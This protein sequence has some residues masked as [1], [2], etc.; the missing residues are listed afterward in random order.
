[1]KFSYSLLKKLAPKISSKEALIEKLNFHAFEAVDVPG[2]TIEIAI[3]PNRF[4]D[5]SSHWG[6][7]QIAVALFGGTL[8]KL[9]GRE[10]KVE[11]KGTAP[12][13][14]VTSR[15]SCIRYAGRYFEIPSQGQSPDWLKE[16]LTACGMRSINAVVD[17]MNYVMLE[18]GQPLHAFDAELVEGGIEVRNAKAGEEMRTIDNQDIK[19]GESDLVI[20]DQKGPL[21]I[22]GIKGGKRAEIT[23]R[24]RKIIVEAAN[25][26]PVGIYKTTRQINLLTDASSRFAHGLSPISVEWGMKRATELLKEVAKAKVGE[27][28][29]VN[30]WKP[31]KRLLKF[32]IKRFNQLTGLELEEKEALGYLKKLG[33][34]ITGRFVEIP[35]TRADISIFEDL[36]EEVVNLYGYQKLPAKAPHVP[37]LPARKEDDVL[38]KDKARAVLKGFGLSEV[39]NYTF[40][41]RQDL[42][43]YAEPKWWNAPSLLNPVSAE[44]QYLRPAL[45]IG[46]MKNIES[47]LRFF[48]DVRVFEV[49]KTFVEKDKLIV[50]ETKLG[51]A[52][53]ARSGNPILELKGMADELLKQLGLTDI[54]FRDLEW[55]L[56]HLEQSK[57]LRIESDHQV[58]G[59]LGVPKGEQGMAI[60]EIDLE[61]SL[62]LVQGE[63]E[64]EPLS[65]YPSVDRDISIF[66]G[67]D[68]RID[69][70]MAA[71]ENAAP[72]LLDDVDLLDYYDPSIEGKNTKKDH[73]SLTFRLVFQSGDHTLTDEEVNAEMT[74]IILLLEE[75][76]GAEVR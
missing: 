34:K 24:T 5:A 17:V 66:V 60:L 40:L 25:F 44:F 15:K 23:P 69:Q 18:T 3:T 14:K 2:D 73:K 68:V 26:D 31:S 50:E 10:L 70:L 7:A 12:E 47:N 51:I 49:G 28:T 53:G 71:M 61:K 21:A 64:Y 36:V 6:M 62:K 59:Y 37:I 43:K 35:V 52:L 13:I 8:G 75:K 9:G 4:A 29:E 30:F 63:K 76:F 11:K 1:M 57:S 19:L 65:K 42:S 32:D 67:Q 41:S 46:L 72:A 74:K 27:M 39:Y 22:A 16:I 33:F 55:D 58:I 54:F 38:L 56:R 20:A 48:K 45:A